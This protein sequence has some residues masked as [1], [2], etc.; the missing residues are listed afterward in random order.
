MQEGEAQGVDVDCSCNVQLNVSAV[1]VASS[2]GIVLQRCLPAV[3]HV[4]RQLTVRGDPNAADANRAPATPRAMQTPTKRT[5][6]ATWQ[7]LSCGWERNPLQDL[8]CAVCRRKDG[9]T[10]P[11]LSMTAFVEMRVAGVNFVV[12]EIPVSASAFIKSWDVMQN[13]VKVSLLATVLCLWWAMV[14]LLP[15]ATF[16][17]LYTLT[18][19]RSSFL[20]ASL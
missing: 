11:K 9:S 3:D 7:C 4:L 13:S 15:W 8:A 18:L 1:R 20:V 5:P 6:A 2:V 16:R 19:R 10:W 14:C 12:F 17:K